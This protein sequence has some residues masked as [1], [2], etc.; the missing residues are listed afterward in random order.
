M[1]A[2]ERRRERRREAIDL[3]ARASWEGRPHDEGTRDLGLRGS[4]LNLGPA[5]GWE[6]IPEKKRT[7]ENT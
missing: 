1:T 6:N 3:P 5:E 2:R 4:C 7:G